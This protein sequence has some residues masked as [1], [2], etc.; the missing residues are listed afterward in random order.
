MNVGD[1]HREMNQKHLWNSSLSSD[2]RIDLKES[3]EAF[4]SE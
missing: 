4:W 2:I 1:F 3:F